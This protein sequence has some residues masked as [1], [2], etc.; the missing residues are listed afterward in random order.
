[1]FLLQTETTSKALS[2][3]KDR[4]QAAATWAMSIVHFLLLKTMIDHGQDSKYFI[5]GIV[6][7]SIAI[8]L[9]IIVGV[10]ASRVSIIDKF[11]KT[12]NDHLAEEEKCWRNCIRC[13]DED[14]E[15]KE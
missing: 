15:R 7:I 2:D 12:F 11:F 3:T 6:M 9:Q 1:M 10:I 8:A 13:K 5:P 4:A 14:I